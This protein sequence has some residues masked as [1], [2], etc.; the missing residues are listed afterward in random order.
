MGFIT[1]VDAEVEYRPRRKRGFQSAAGFACRLG[2][3]LIAAGARALER[4]F[5]RFSMR[6]VDAR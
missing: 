6:H 4:R 5:V 3:P 1:N 2:Q